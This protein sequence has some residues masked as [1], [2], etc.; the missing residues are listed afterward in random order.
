MIISIILASL[1]LRAFLYLGP[2][3]TNDPWKYRFFPTE[4]A[5]FLFGTLAGFVA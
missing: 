2:H 5:L 1:G 3:W 4:L